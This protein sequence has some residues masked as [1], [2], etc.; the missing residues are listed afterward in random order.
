MRII[1]RRFFGA[2]LITLT[3][4]VL[5]ADNNCNYK[6]AQFIGVIK[7][8]YNFQDDYAQVGECS[9]NLEI[10]ISEYWPDI[11]E[12]CVLDLSEVITNTFTYDYYHETNNVS[13][14]FSTEGQIISG[15]IVKKNDKITI[16]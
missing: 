5:A 4:N 9:F 8:F 6:E 16:K 11:T 1:L 15:S 7:N 3:T 10:K 12:E 13:C 2:L 14:P